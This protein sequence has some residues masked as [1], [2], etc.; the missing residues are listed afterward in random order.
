MRVTIEIEYSGDM[1][2]KELEEYIER[3]LIGL[4]KTE[5]KFPSDGGKV[6]KKKKS[7]AAAPALAAEP[8]PMTDGSFLEYEPP[9]STGDPQKVAGVPPDAGGH[10]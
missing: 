9:E 7:I 4:G 8:R 3:K 10:G 6:K 2:P 5:V 1:N